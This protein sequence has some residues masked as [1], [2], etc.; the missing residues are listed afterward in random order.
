MPSFTESC[1]GSRHTVRS[2]PCERP[3]SL[4]ERRCFAQPELLQ[5]PDARPARTRRHCTGQR[6]D[7]NKGGGHLFAR[8]HVRVPHKKLR[9]GGRARRRGRTREFLEHVDQVSLT[10]SDLDERDQR[11]PPPPV[12]TKLKLRRSRKSYY[13]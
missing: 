13:P 5:V 9:R 8:R 2:G 7:K 6:A 3:R 12:I 1:R 4:P 11:P 10:L